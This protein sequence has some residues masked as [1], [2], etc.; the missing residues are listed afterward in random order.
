M[1]ENVWILGLGAVTNLKL[2]EKNSKQF[3]QL[4]DYNNL[5]FTLQT[6]KGEREV[7]VVIEDEGV[8]RIKLL[9]HVNI[10]RDTL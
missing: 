6:R 9:A 1:F 7:C 2:Y 5:L 8:K 3:H 4:V 10:L